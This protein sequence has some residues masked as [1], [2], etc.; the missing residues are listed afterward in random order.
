MWGLA[1]SHG[2]VPREVHGMI[3][4]SIFPELLVE[5]EAMAVL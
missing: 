3:E 2:T 1:S 4:Q 5:I